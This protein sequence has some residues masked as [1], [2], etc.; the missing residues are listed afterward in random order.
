MKTALAALALLYPITLFAGAQ[1]AGPSCSELEVGDYASFKEYLSTYFTADEEYTCITVTNDNGAAVFEFIGNPSD[2]TLTCASGYKVQANGKNDWFS[3]AAWES[4]TLL[5]DDSKRDIQ[6]VMGTD[7]VLAEQT[8]NKP[9]TAHVWG[10]KYDEKYVQFDPMN[11]RVDST[12][13][14]FFHKNYDGF[15]PHVTS[16]EKCAGTPC[17]NASSNRILYQTLGCCN[18]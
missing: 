6:S 13:M 9:S 4:V 14:Y 18:C 8:W 17:D 1:T 11:M 5:W 10:F 7:Y 12:V 3:V 16:M 2:D 15:Y